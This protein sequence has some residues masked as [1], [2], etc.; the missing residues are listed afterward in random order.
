MKPDDFLM[1]DYQKA[2][3]N[4]SLRKNKSYYMDGR[5]EAPNKIIEH[6]TKTFSIKPQK[7]SNNSQG[8]R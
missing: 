6:H 4:I 1:K 7:Q 3:I 8:R 5:K 2:N